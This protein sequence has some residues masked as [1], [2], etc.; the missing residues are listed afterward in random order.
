MDVHCRSGP[1]E[2]GDVGISTVDEGRHQLYE[3]QLRY[4]GRRKQ[5]EVMDKSVKEDNVKRDNFIDRSKGKRTLMVLT[6]SGLP[7]KEGNTDYL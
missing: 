4:R 5:Q 2:V 7:Y 6:L 3:T 1:K